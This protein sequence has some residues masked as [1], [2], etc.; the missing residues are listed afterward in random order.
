MINFDN[1][2]GKNIKKHNGNWPRNPEN[3][4]KI[5]INEV[6]GSGK[7]NTLL[8]L[9]NHQPDIDKICLYTKYPY[10]AKYQMLINKR[11]SV[12]LKH[13]NDSKSVVEYSNDMDDAYKNT[14][15]YSILKKMLIALYD[16]YNHL[17]C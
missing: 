2:I 9:V 11:K 14:D 15:K 17:I 4:F 13:C 3:S 16:H 5:L 1:V 12:G 6:S 10:K 7:T 8:N